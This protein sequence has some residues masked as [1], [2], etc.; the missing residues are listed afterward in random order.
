MFHQISKHF[1]AF[2]RNSAAP[3]F[4]NLILSVWISD[5]THLLVFDILHPVL[6]PFKYRSL[7]WDIERKMT[8][9][10]GMLRTGRGALEAAYNQF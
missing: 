7:K 8:N 6:L 4:L 1:E 5:K 3:H 2:L 9:L 10:Q